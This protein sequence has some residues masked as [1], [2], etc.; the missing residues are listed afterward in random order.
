M[1]SM[2]SSQAAG[3]TDAGSGRPARLLAM[4]CHGDPYAELPLMWQLCDALAQRQYAVTVLDGTKSE[5]EE[6]PGLAQVLEQGWYPHRT[7]TQNQPWQVLPSRWGLQT[8]ATLSPQSLATDLQWCQL[9]SADSVLL[10]Y[11]TADTLAPWALRTGVHPLLALSSAKTSLMTSYLALKRL[12]HHGGVAPTVVQRLEHDMPD[13]AHAQAVAQSLTDCARHFLQLDIQ[14]R[15]L[16]DDDPTA[17]AMDALVQTLLQESVTLEPSWTA[18][19]SGRGRETQTFA[20]RI[21]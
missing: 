1:P 10:L 17:P 6:N 13:V 4:V 2:R 7:A 8:L 9:A 14:V 18:T 15:R 12:W 11:A 21:N 19:P 16:T 20:T 5:T 3:L